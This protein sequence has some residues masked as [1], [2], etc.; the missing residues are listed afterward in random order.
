M[1]NFRKFEK[2]AILWRAKKTFFIQNAGESELWVLVVRGLRKQRKETLTC[3][4]FTVY[5]FLQFLDYL[6]SKTNSVFK[7]ERAKVYQDMTYPLSCYWIASS[8][9]T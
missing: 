1:N 9:N 3:F 8:H 7:E 5:S 2:I 6:F 4:L